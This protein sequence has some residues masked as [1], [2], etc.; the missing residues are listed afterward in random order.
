M[1]THFHLFT[2]DNGCLLTR[3]GYILHQIIDD[4]PYLRHRKTRRRIQYKC[5][6][7]IC[8]LKIPIRKH[9][10]YGTIG[11]SLT[12]HEM[13]KTTNAKVR[14]YTIQPN[15]AVI[16]DISSMYDDFNGFVVSPKEPSIIPFLLT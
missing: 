16:G 13:R 5:I 11:Q 7:C 2:A 9:T 12:S 15:F 3:R 4:S 14:K 10:L 1:S 6:S 8:C